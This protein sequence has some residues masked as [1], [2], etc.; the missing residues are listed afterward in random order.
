[1]ASEVEEQE[2]IFSKSNRPQVIYEQSRANVLYGMGVIFA[3][4]IIFLIYKISIGSVN[5][6]T[7][8]TI[9]PVAKK[10]TF[11]AVNKLKTYAKDLGL[12]T[13]TFNKCL[14]SNEKAVAVNDDV[15]YGQDLL[16]A[17]APVFFVNGQLLAGNLSYEVFKEVIDA[18]ISG[19][20]SA[21]CGNY[22]PELQKLCSNPKKKIFVPKAIEINASDSPSIGAPNGKVIITEFSDFQCSFCAKADK[23]MKQILEQYQEDVTLY[24]KQYPLTLDHL[25]SQKAAEA[26]LCA[27]DQGKFWEWQDKIFSLYDN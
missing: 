2:V 24:F 23:V 7:V 16:L 10:E 3:L 9:T 18:Q 8:K 1:M 26:S 27:E 17:G 12:N 4:A 11:L 21:E 25:D 14:D 15:V 5:K 19:T 13:E 6:S 22:S 20:S